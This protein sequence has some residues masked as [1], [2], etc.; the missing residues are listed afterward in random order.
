MCT[1]ENL[2]KICQKYLA[3]LNLIFILMFIMLKV[4]KKTFINLVLGRKLKNQI[5]F[6]IYLVICCLLLNK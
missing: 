6:N 3:T 5:Q 4:R 1:F 2:E